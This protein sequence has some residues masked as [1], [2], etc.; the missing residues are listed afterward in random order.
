M[1]SARFASRHPAVTFYAVVFPI[2][3]GGLFLIVGGPGAIPART[4]TV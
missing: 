3:W 2:S 1:A 4:S